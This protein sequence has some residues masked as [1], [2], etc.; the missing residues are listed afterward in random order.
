MKTLAFIS[1]SRKD[2]SVAHWLHSKLEKY[3]YPKVSISIENRPPDKKYLRPIFID[4]KDLSV[5]EHPFNEKIK[6]A[7]RDS[8]FL[9]LICSKH[10]VCSEFVNKEVT[11]FLEVHN[12]DYSKIVPIF[13]DNVDDN[14]PPSIAKSSVMQRHFPI[15]NTT[16][17]EKSEA[18]TYCFYQIAAYLLGID[19]SYLYNRYENY[20]A[21]RKKKHYM[22]VGILVLS[23]ILIILSLFSQYRKQQDLAQFEKNVFPRSVMVG[24]VNNFLRPVISYM[25]NKNQNF[26]I[27][28]LMPIKQ[29]EILNHQKRIDDIRYDIVKKLGADSLKFLRL[30]TF[31][32]RGSTVTTICTKD[33]RYN[34]IFLDFASTTSS[35]LE[36]AEYKKSHEAYRQTDIDDLILEYANTFV[37]EAKQKLQKDSVFVDFYFSQD[38]LVS[39]LKE[40]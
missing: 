19:F 6:A 15:Y 37:S 21:K 20:A 10:S 23:L 5:D 8:R 40:Y 11:Y 39:R 26:K 24:Y 31:M 27:Y 12:F 16:L 9:I 28:V 30:P 35:F 25:K 3:P 2:K 1:Y 29:E 4:V 38:D 36:V 18:N 14:I 33:N 22:Y 32:K 7:L 17:S 13:I 34:N